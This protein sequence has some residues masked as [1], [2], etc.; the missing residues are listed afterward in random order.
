MAQNEDE[1][2]LAATGYILTAERGTVAPEERDIRRI[3]DVIPEEWAD[4]GHTSREDLPSWGVDGGEPEVKGTWQNQALRSVVTEAPTES[5]SMVVHQVNREILA[6]YTG[7]GTGENAEGQRDENVYHASARFGQ[8]LE[9]AL[10]IVIVDG[11]RWCAFYAPRVSFSRDDDIELDS[12]EFMTFPLKATFLQ[13][14]GMPFYDWIS[15]QL[16]AEPLPD[17]MTEGSSGGGSGGNGEG[18]LPDEETA[19][20]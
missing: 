11:D 13:E 12:E 14:S 4:I 16:D 18:E 2:I 1:V 8:N 20:V 17:G 15:P 5:L 10:L 3:P 6:Y 9:R 19:G 7:R